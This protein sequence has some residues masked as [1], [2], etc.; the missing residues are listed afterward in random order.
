[1]V[2]RPASQSASTR[3]RRSIEYAA[4]AT[5]PCAATRY[6]RVRAPGARPFLKLL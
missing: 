6:T 2:F 4:I 3:I 1:L 5:P